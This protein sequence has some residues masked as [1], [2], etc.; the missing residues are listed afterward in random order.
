MKKNTMR[1]ILVAALVAIV[2]SSIVTVPVAFKAC[3]TGLRLISISNKIAGIE[4]NVSISKPGC[5]W[6]PERI[7]EYQKLTAEREEIY[8]SPDRVVRTFATASNAIQL[9]ILLG[10]ALATFVQIYAATVLVP[11]CKQKV[12]KRLKKNSGIN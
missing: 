5:G 3:R 9:L 11:F 6:T 2:L 4:A 8:N 7:E 1:K 10:L 12:Q